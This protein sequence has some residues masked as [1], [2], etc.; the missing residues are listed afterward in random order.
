MKR[1]LAVALLL[2][3]I[4]ILAQQPQPRP[5]E[6]KRVVK[7]HVSMREA[8]KSKRYWLT[9]AGIFASSVFDAESTARCITRHPQCQEFNPIFGP[10][11][12]RK[13]LYGIKFALS[14]EQAFALLLYR[15]LDLEDDISWRQWCEANPD[16]ANYQK[17]CVGHTHAVSGW[18]RWWGVG[19]IPIGVN[20][21]SGIYNSARR[22]PTVCPSGTVCR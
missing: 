21:A 2:P 15:R 16:D 3:T 8:A 10:R 11:P 19:L 18:P 5:V 4:P 6:K 12:S 13:R 7:P 9:V 17:Y 20:A 22:F 1:L 14:A